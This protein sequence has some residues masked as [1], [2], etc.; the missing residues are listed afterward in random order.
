MKPGPDKHR[1]LIES[2]PDAFAYHQIVTDEEG[3]P[4]DYIFLEINN[5]FEKMTGL[6]RDEVIGK[7]VTT[8]LP[9][10]EK[11]DFDWIGTFGQVA[12]SGKPARFETNSEP[13]GRWYDVSAYSNEHGYFTAVFRDITESKKTEHALQK[14]EANYR[15][16]VENINEVVYIL[17]ENAS[18]TYI[19]PSVEFISGYTPSELTKMRFTDFVHPDDLE[20]RIEQFFKIMSG[21]N[22]ASEYRFITKDG[23]IVW[24]R[25]AARPVVRNGRVVGVQGVLSDITERKQ[26][27]E[28]LKLKEEYL[29][30][31]LESQNDLVVRIDLENR[32]NYVNDAYCKT[33]GKTREELV[34]KSFTPLVHEEDIETTLQ[35]MEKLYV[36]P[37]R[38]YVE[39]RAMTVHGW[40]WIAWEDSGILNDEGELVE[41]QGVGRDITNRK[42][43][44]EALRYHYEFEK[45]V[46]EI[47]SYFINL[48]VDQIDEGIKY[49]LKECGDF[50]QVER[51]YLFLLSPD[52]QSLSM[53]HEWHKKEIEPQINRLQSIPIGKR[54][55]WYAQVI[56]KGYVHIPDVNDMPEEA[57]AERNEFLKQN[58]TSLLSI[59]IIADGKLIGHLGLDAIKEKKTWS[60]EQIN[61]LKVLAE[62]ISHALERQW[63]DKKI[64]Y[65]SFYDQLTGLYNRHFL[66]EEIQRLDTGR[67]LPISIIMADLNGLKL[68][69]DTYGH[70]VGDE[71]LICT[72]DVLK[73]SCREEDIITRWGGD[74]FVILLPQTTI[75]EAQQI[76]NR[77]KDRCRDAYVKDMPVSIALGLSIKEDTDKDLLMVLKDAEDN[78]YKEKLVKSQSAKSAVLK[79][80]L[81][82]LEEKSF[83]TEGHA[84]NMQETASKIAEKVNIPDS[85]INRL[86]LL[87]TLH[88][89]G[90]INIDEKILTKTEPL[91]S[92]EWELI[93][94]HPETGYRIALAAEEF[95]HVAG[96]ILAHHEHWDGSGYP[97]GLKGEE[98]PLLARIVAIADTYE[99]MSRGRPYKNALTT[100]EIKAEFKRRAGTQFDPELVE[101][102]LAIIDDGIDK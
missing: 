40:R 84:Q 56:E 81:K 88:D 14:S 1:L 64:R 7:R 15:D 17:D 50:F 67:Q 85:E 89:I 86:R 55:W 44:E 82:A 68:V 10:I 80:L 74:E 102:F 62:L 8:V 92:E 87:I 2:L 9:E 65:L 63:N 28:E 94:K 21:F 53:T 77:I 99:V 4:H 66:E 78:M 49:A 52:G 101:I 6:E 61:L 70:G 27:E 35:A 39:Q 38:T 93:K 42:Q 43:A 73:N 72:A 59:P 26:A 79:T 12:L 91:T 30:G 69:N 34:G 58:I 46:S 75:T 57:E 22:E 48:P 29:R 32:L 45:M 37:Y 31:I 23:R 100:E 19:S 98:I 13:L 90:K 97:Q 5:A 41:I 83:E 20:G 36:P 11:S 96:D 24:V 95:A 47:A 60:E 25:T 76:E 51:S 54:P 71:M 18:I 3:A 33:F 16:L